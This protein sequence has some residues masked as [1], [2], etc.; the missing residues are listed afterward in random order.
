MAA[1]AAQEVDDGKQHQPLQPSWPCHPCRSYQ[2]RCGIVPSNHGEARD[3]GRHTK[4]VRWAMCNWSRC[5]FQEGGNGGGACV[6]AWQQR[7]F[8]DEILHCSWAASVTDL[9]PQNENMALAACVTKCKYVAICDCEIHAAKL[10]ERPG[11]H[12]SSLS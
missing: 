7:C 6:V 5:S 3:F 11:T 9:T 12:V 10:K 1:E 4:R 8:L 2:P